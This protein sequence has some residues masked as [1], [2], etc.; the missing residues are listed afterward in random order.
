M[1]I[2]RTHRAMRAAGVTA[3][4]HVYEGVSHGGF[5]ALLDAPETE[6]FFRELCAFLRRYLNAFPPTAR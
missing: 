3:E 5:I 4:L 6:D 2:T 1:P